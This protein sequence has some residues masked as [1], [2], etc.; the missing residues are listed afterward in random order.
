MNTD[1]T[2]EERFYKEFP[3]GRVYFRGKSGVK[4]AF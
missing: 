4:E 2:M 3:N 1:K